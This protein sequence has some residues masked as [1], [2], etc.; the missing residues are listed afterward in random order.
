VYIAI[1]AVGIPNSMMT[2]AR[3][4][5]PSMVVLL[6]W[7]PGTAER[8]LLSGRDTQAGAGK[9]LHSQ[10]DAPETLPRK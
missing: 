9:F 5:I 6:R 8:H 2:A 10:L 7:R 4:V 3:P 1:A